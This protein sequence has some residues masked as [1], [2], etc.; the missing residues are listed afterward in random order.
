M[1]SVEADPAM[2]PPS[3]D[4]WMT[5]DSSRSVRTCDSSSCGSMPSRRTVAL[6]APL[7]KLMIGPKIMP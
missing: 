7:R 3:A 4:A 1:S 5:S 2:V 6:A